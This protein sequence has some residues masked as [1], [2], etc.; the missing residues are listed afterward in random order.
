[1]LVIIYFRKYHIW[2]MKR[3][4]TD[5]FERRDVILHQVSALVQRLMAEKPGKKEAEKTFK[6]WNEK[7]KRN[8]GFEDRAENF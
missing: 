7:A 5:L 8:I 3:K 2:T 6:R 4:R 1:M